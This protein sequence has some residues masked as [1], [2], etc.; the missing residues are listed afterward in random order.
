MLTSQSLDLEL[1][2][3]AIRQPVPTP[4]FSWLKEERS[5]VILVPIGHTEQHGFHLPLNVDTIC[6][7]AVLRWWMRPTL[8]LYP[9]TI[10]GRRRRMGSQS[11]LGR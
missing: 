1:G 8:L 5:K 7:E 6:I 3:Q 10:L 9:M 4:E 2:T 11:T